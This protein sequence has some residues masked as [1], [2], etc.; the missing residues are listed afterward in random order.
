MNENPNNHQRDQPESLLTYDEA[1]EQLGLPAW[2][3][4][5]AAN[6]GLIPTYSLLNA[7][8]YVRRSD[9]LKAMQQS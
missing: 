2:K 1:A 9:I 6:A 4:R 5:R 3:I 8:K 7:K